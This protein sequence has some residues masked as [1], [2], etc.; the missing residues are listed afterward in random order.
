MSEKGQG[1]DN[2]DA[3]LKARL[4]KLSGAIK[5]EMT[6]VAEERDA[7]GKKQP[8]IGLGSA[9]G[10]G[11][12]VSTELVAGVLVGGFIGWWIDRWLDSSPFGLLIMLMI[13]MLAGFWNVYKMSM[14]SSTSGHQNNGKD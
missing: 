5:T 8:I 3:E 1:P 13:G 2:Q 7:T 4:D 14:R 9:M 11:I 10:M 12:R 6:H